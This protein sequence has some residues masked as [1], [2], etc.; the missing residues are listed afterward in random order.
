MTSNF[1]FIHKQFKINGFHYSNED[2]LQFASHFVKEGEPY[3]HEIGDFLHHW[4]NDDDFVEVKTSG[5]TGIPKNLKIK[6]EAMV[7]SALATGD[8]FNLKSGDTALHCL[9]TQF[10]A[11]KMML[12]RAMI[13]G[14]E[15]DII[16]PTSKPIFDYNKM[17]HFCA[18]IP[19]Q[20]ENCLENCSNIKT[21]IVGGASVSNT[22]NDKI[23]SIDSD[24]YETYGMTETVTHIALK[25]LNNLLS[26]REGTTKQS[27]KPYFKLLPNISISQDERDC[28]VIEA[29]NL[30]EEKIITND[31]VKI[32]SETEFEWLGRF[33]NVINSGGL[34]LFPE[35]I[36]A[37][38]K[39]H[40]SERFFIASKPHKTLGEQLIL[41]VEGN[42]DTV[43]ISAFSEL[44]KHEKPKHIFTVKQFVETTS[45]K[46]QRKKTLELISLS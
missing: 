3:Q 21:I 15:I 38:L 1:S 29:P 36:E 2:L 30:S 9:P 31:I 18:M 4:L 34:K 24:V 33:D 23:Q 43:D 13:L 27:A 12:V 19:L 40:I 32:H 39:K 8:F 41:V 45:G 10:I 25:K 42:I 44:K 26:L 16:A 7:N 46:I 35:Q 28:L 5:S 22:L 11:G 20:V 14:L 37:K 6:K 17:Y